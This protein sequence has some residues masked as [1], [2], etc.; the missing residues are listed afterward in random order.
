MWPEVLFILDYPVTSL[1]NIRKI[2]WWYLR[3]TG[4]PDG[5]NWM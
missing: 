2:I 3:L 1:M 5:G 4:N